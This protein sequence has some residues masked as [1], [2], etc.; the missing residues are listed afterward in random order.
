MKSTAT[1]R[2][3]YMIVNFSNIK[4]IELVTIIRPNNLNDHNN[5][6][7]LCVFK[8][9]LFNN[10]LELC[11]RT[12]YDEWNDPSICSNRLR[13]ILLLEWRVNAIKML[14][15]HLPH[16]R[17]KVANTE[18]KEEPKKKNRFRAALIDNWR[19]GWLKVLMKLEIFRLRKRGKDGLIWY[20]IYYIYVYRF[21]WCWLWFVDVHCTMQ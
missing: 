1:T 15:G 20:T 7:Q 17:H 21:G 9:I 6:T 14:T 18:G 13:A 3:A 4:K 11:V 5:R 8:P 19:R 16:Y 10:S 2:T 12:G